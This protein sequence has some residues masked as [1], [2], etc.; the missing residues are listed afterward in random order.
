MNCTETGD[1]RVVANG[2]VT[3]NGSI[4]RE[5]SVIA[6]LA[7]VGHVCVAEEEVVI[8]DPSWCIWGGSSVDGDVLSEGVVITDMEM[9]GF[10]LKL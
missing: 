10:L 9:G 3:R 1:D 4:V 7:F 8:S 5:D 2:N 6:D